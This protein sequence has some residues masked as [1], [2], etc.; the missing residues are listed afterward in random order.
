MAKKRKTTDGFDHIGN[1]LNFSG[2]EAYNLLRTNLMFSIRKEEDRARIVGVTSSIHG[3]GKSLTAINTAYSLAENGYKVLIID[4]DMRLPT[5][6]KK[7]GLKK[8]AGLSNILAGMDT[9]DDILFKDVIVKGLN[10]V[11]AGDIPPNPSELLGSAQFKSLIENLGGYYDFIILDL[12]P[13]GEVSDALV[14]SKRVDG[15]VVVV[16]QDYTNQADLAYTM[17]QLE[18]VNAKVIGFVCNY[19]SGK[20]HKYGYGKYGKYKKYKYAQKPAK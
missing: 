16:R 11:Q 10:V 20:D 9:D 13:V 7:L 5:L 17:R 1:L 19:A 12:P 2:K 18:L 6:D 15:M 4:C 3:E 8:S 14:A